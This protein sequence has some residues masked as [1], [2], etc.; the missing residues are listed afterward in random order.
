MYIFL[1][2]IPYIYHK[3][4]LHRFSFIFHFHIFRF[5]SISFF[6][7][8]PSF[9][10]K[11]DNDENAIWFFLL[12]LLMDCETMSLTF[13]TLPPIQSQPSHL[14]TTYS[15]II[16]KKNEMK[17]NGIP[18]VYTQ[19]SQSHRYEKKAQQQKKNSTITTPSPI[20]IICPR[21]H[22]YIQH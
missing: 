2:R 22:Q 17:W 21:R 11:Q 16:T 14:Y 12:Y 3:E 8:L 20:L 9:K 13:L 15:A 18:F 7:G 4:N 5:Y 1:F 19:T 6:F 10:F